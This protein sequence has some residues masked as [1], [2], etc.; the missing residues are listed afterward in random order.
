MQKRLPMER[1]YWPTIIALKHHCGQSCQQT[2]ASKRL[3]RH[4]PCFPDRRT[5]ARMTLLQT[6]DGW[7]HNVSK[8]SRLKYVQENVALRRKPEKSACRTGKMTKCHL[9]VA[10]ASTGLLTLSCH[11]NGLWLAI[12]VAFEVWHEE[13]KRKAPVWIRADLFMSFS[14]WL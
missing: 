8:L 7:D 3:M 2:K 9:T 5:L 12:R 10:Y 6:R 13:M 11:I 14:N 4:Q 1:R